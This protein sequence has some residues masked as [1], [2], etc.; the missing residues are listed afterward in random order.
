MSRAR[1]I[2]GLF[3]YTENL[4]KP[5]RFDHFNQLRQEVSMKRVA[6]YLRVSTSKQDTDNQRRELEAVAKRSGWEVVKSTRMPA[7]VAPRAG[8]SDLGSMP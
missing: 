1:K 6:S 2:I 3:G 7:L 4:S 8:T 5:F